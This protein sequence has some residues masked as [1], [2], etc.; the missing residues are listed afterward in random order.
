ML[1]PL[2]PFRTVVVQHQLVVGQ[3]GIP[4]QLVP[5]QVGTESEPLPGPTDA[6]ER[7][8]NRTFWQR[9]ID[10]ICFDHPDQSPPRHGGNNWVR[11]ALPD[12]LGWITGFRS[13]DRAGFFFA[14][15]GDAG[16]RIFEN[17]S[18]SAPLLQGEIGSN[19]DLDVESD[20]LF[21]ATIGVYHARQFDDEASDGGLMEWLKSAANRMITALRPRL[22]AWSTSADILDQ[23]FQ[24]SDP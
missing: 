5:I 3:G 24:Q 14:L 22:A 18:A 9:F 1:L 13:R 12:P 20:E 6:G 2:V 10:E 23:D 17:L 19:L 7:E 21:K 8:R 11:M 15:K 4:L 16:R